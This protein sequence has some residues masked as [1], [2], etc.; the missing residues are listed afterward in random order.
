MEG[1]VRVLEDMV[2]LVFFEWCE[3]IE[4]V[5][6]EMDGEIEGEEMSS[7]SFSLG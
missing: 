7:S 4:I 5:Y 3:E 6:R 1:K 2:G